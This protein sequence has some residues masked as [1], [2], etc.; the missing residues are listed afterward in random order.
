MFEE[1]YTLFE[2]NTAEHGAAIYLDLN[3]RITFNVNSAVSFRKNEARKYGGAI[4]CS[5]SNYSNCYRNVSDT[6]RVINNNSKTIQFSNNAASI[7]GDSVYLNVQQ[8]CDKHFSSASNVVLHPFGDKMVTS[9][10]QLKL[11][12]PASLVNFT[13]I[14]KFNDTY[15]IRNIM[16]G[17]NITI[18]S[19][20]LDYNNKPAGVASFLIS[21]IKGTDE[22]YSIN[23][24][25]GLSIGCHSFQGISNLQIIGNL[26]SNSSLSSSYFRVI[27]ND[28]LRNYWSDNDYTMIHVRSSYDSI[29]ALKPTEV[30]LIIEIS[31]YCHAGFHYT[32]KD[33]KCICYSTNNIISCTGSDA[34]IRR[35]YWFGTVNNQATVAVCPVN[36]C[37]FDRCEGANAMCRL[38]ASP[39]DQCSE[40]RLGIGCGKCEDG[41]TLSFDSV[42]CVNINECTTGHSI[43]VVT[44]TCVY[45]IFTIVMVFAVMYFKVGIGYFYSITFYYSVIDILLG[46]ALHTSDSLYKMVTIVSSLARLTPQ[47]LGQLCFVRG[48]SGIDQQYIHYIHPLAILFILVLI[49]ASARFSPRLSLFVSRG[50]IHVICFLLLLSYT[51]I[52]STSLLLMRPLT[53][54]GINKIYTYLSPDIQ[55][56]HGRHLVYGLVALACGMIIVIGLPLLLLLEPFLNSKISFTRIKP[57]LDQFQGHYKDKYRC[58]AS[59]YMIC[60]LVLLIIVNANINNV[61]TVA[62][63]QLGALVVMTLIHFIVRPY[64]NNLLNCVDGFLLLTT[65]MVVMLQPFEASNGFT[66][67]TVIGLS[68]FLV[69]LPLFVYM[70]LIIPFMN[71]QYIEKIVISLFSV[72]SPK[73]IEARNRGF[74]LQSTSRDVY[75]VTVDEELRSSTATTVV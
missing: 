3:S 4:F 45:W 63:L 33:N 8:T 70:V 14:T 19:C 66:T 2:N 52:A 22:R 26:L 43:L 53:F 37:N 30:Y 32:Q 60:R 49:S 44:M 58:F 20:L 74:E 56:F 10:K 71:K 27:D 73:R 69:L 72:K 15:V 67:N 11:D 6:L 61:F 65:I 12:P 5:V 38:S 48:L 24:S 51:S 16:L 57:L 13:N 39:D 59:Y 41:Y 62:Y 34:D 64:T 9:P 55:Y 7:G 47:F 29:Y 42:D 36:Y 17:Q 46:Q 21:H 68:Y 28:V 31:A 50:V 35:G 40:H 18:P 25:R 23:A 75:Q 1:G 54:T